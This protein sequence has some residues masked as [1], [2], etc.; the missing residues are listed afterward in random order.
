M[1]DPASR[2]A[3]MSLA[4]FD[5]A[6]FDMD[7]L[8]IDS[9]PFW[10]RAERESFA[11]VGIHITEEMSKVTA[12]MTTAE[13]ARYWYAFRPWQGRTTDDLELAVMNRVRALIDSHGSALPGVREMLGACRERGWQT[14]LASNSPSMLCE[15]VLGALELEG[16]FDVVLSAEQVPR[17]K[18]APDIYLEAARRL[19]VSPAR[20]IAFEDSVSGV[21]AARGAGMTVIAIPSA[22][23]S[24]G[25]GPEPHATYVSL[26]TFWRAHFFS[27]ASI[28]LKDNPG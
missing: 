8:L 14:A 26:Q 3:A 13:V 2:G 12:S 6:I 1:S 19:R 24:F 18:P 21:R 25:T 17:G 28:V 15:H 4:R 27:P 20:C 10:K 7:G 16:M 9:E 23:Q 22:G 11:E 5:A